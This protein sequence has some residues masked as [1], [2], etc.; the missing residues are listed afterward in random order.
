[1]R[2]IEIL[3]KLAFLILGLFLIFTKDLGNA[4]L[5]LFLIVSILLGVV[6]MLNKNMSYRYPA[7]FKH[8]DRLILIRRV[9]GALLIVFGATMSYLI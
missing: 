2:Y 3:L 1:M 9:E 8:F 6:L 7:K 5:S 4:C